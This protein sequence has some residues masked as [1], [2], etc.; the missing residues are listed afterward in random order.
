MEKVLSQQKL[1]LFED[2]AMNRI[3]GY[4]PSKNLV[5][6]NKKYVKNVIE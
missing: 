5:S 1:W 2:E 3:I 6:F 4:E